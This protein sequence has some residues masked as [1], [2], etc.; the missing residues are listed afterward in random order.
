MQL[1]IFLHRMIFDIGIYF[2]L[3]LVFF[4]L[5][6]SCIVS[7]VGQKKD[8]PRSVYEPIVK[9]QGGCFIV[10]GSLLFSWW[11]RGIM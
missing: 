1:I 9:G 8:C 5:L 7:S 4:F 3:K 6:S 10:T 11:R 2:D